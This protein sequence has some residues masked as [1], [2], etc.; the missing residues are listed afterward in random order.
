MKHPKIALLAI[1]L[2][3]TVPT[4]ARAQDKD[5]MKPKRM[6]HAQMVKAA[7]ITPV[8]ARAV[9][10]REVPG[11][12]VSRYYLRQDEG[13]VMYEYTLKVPEK[14]G[15][16]VVKINAMSGSMIEHTHKGGVATTAASAKAVVKKPDHP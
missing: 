7:K 9:A 14:S 6:T 13:V 16:E 4:L 8:E 11:G 5:A 12:K 1:A 3:V 2:A 15:S 10:L